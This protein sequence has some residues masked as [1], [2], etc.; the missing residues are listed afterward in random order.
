MKKVINEKIKIKLKEITS[1][2]DSP[3]IRQ[4]QVIMA[5][6]LCRFF[7]YSEDAGLTYLVEA[8][9]GVGKSFA[10][11]TAVFEHLSINKERENTVV[12]AT[13]TISLQEQLLKKDIPVIQ[14]FYPDIV[15]EK[16][17]G[18]NNYLC[19]RLFNDDYNGN[20]FDDSSSMEINAKIEN[21]LYR[22]S[23]DGDRAEMPFEISN[24]KWREYASS[25]DTC[26]GSKCPYFKKCYYNKA[27]KKLQKADVIIAN[28]ALI[29]TDIKN[30]FLPDYTHLI[31]DEAHNF[32]KNALRIN[33]TEI[34]QY[35]FDRIIRKLESSYCQAGIARANKKGIIDSWIFDIKLLTEA[36]FTTLPEGRILD[37]ETLNDQNKLLNELHNVSIL[38][39]SI[40]DKNETAIIKLE[41]ENTIK[42]ILELATDMEEFLQQKNK[43]KYFVYWVENQKAFFAPITTDFLKTLWASKTTVL[44]SATLSVAGSFNNIL[45][46]LNLEKQ[47]TFTLKLNSPFDYK[48]NAIV[49]LPS[50]SVSPKEEHFTNYL[51]KAI[52]EIVKKTNG[53]TFILF[54]SFYLLNEVF[55]K[56]KS[57]LQDFMLL[58][59]EKG[60]R[61]LILKE[62]RDKDNSVLFG[63]DTFWEGIDENIN[64]VVITKLPFAVPT[65]PI[66]EAQH[67]KLKEEGKNPFILK[68]VPNCALKLKQGTG[69][70]IR[71]SQ[72]KGVIAILDPRIKA[73]WSKTIVKTLPEMHWV[74]SIDDVS[75]YV[76]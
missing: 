8:G 58:K 45:M 32:E 51:V 24:Q 47:N 63:T 48:K 68:A 27:M 74:E 40:I 59:Q 21:W 52:P 12:I 67:E 20:L 69:R 55:D 56:V 61:N 39:K 6:N 25:A 33:T 23:G 66:E 75:N 42:E 38:L 64:C 76:E 34:N 11:L 30:S 57:D 9:T 71:H 29:L 46:E 4:E 15:V 65:E 62:F 14:K 54:T 2:L 13:N 16:A 41:I 10:Y 37:K 50:F 17:K 35:R 22:D 49:Y 7:N 44:T 60:N 5:Q 53:K 31:I 3:E 43:D 28:H 19:Q 70:L 36:F 1:S 72:K 73:N 26:Y 18:R